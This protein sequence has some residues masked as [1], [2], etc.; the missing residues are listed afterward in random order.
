MEGSLQ[1]WQMDI[2]D[3]TNDLEMFLESVYSKTHDKLTNKL[4]ELESI[5]VSICV[6]CKLHRAEL[7]VCHTIL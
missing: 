2:S 4:L 1:S 6:L 7:G 3:G 5:F